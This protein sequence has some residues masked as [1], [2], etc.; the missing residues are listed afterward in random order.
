MVQVEV[1][2][3]EYSETMEVIPDKLR[4][5]ANEVLQSCVKGKDS[6]GGFLTSDLS[7][8]TAWIVDPEMD[9]EGHYRML[10]QACS[11]MPMP[12]RLVFV[13]HGFP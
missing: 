10:S 5:M 12:P 7:A 4:N 11:P 6:K 13:S 2:G 8:L 1:A 9:L 3:P